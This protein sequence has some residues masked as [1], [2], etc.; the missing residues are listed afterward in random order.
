M[1]KQADD[2]YKLLVKTFPHNIITKERYVK[3]MGQQLFF[4]FYIKD[5]NVLF[6][7]Q[8]RQ[9]SEYVAHFHGD[10]QGYL[11]MKRR[12][13]LK[14]RYCQEEGLSLVTINYDEEITTPAEI[15]EKVNI[16]LDR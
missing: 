6:E 16:A 14:I 10:R 2:I 12:D 9:H 8:G 15:I 3:Y 11:D 7:I 1:S 13:N 5:Y 4:D